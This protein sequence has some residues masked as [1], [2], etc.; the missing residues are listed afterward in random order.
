MSPVSMLEVFAHLAQGD[1]PLLSA[2]HTHAH[3]A[4]IQT[5]A[6]QSQITAFITKMARSFGNKAI[7]KQAELASKR[8]P[9]CQMGA[10]CKGK[11]RCVSRPSLLSIPDMQLYIQT[12]TGFVYNLERTLFAQV[13]LPDNRL[14]GGVYASTLQCID[15]NQYQSRGIA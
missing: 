6:L 15:S 2:S 3:V 10:H 11:S 8:C 1:I 5:A 12:G 7:L 14:Y 4:Y 13:R 9:L